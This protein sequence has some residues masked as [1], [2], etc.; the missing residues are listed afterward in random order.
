[1]HTK[2]PKTYFNTAYGREGEL[3]DTNMSRKE[4]AQLLRK[5]LKKEFPQIKVAVRMNNGRAINVFI[6]SV[7]FQ[8]YSTPYLLAKKS[9]DYTNYNAYIKQYTPNYIAINEKGE[10]VTVER[11]TCPEFTLQGEKLLRKLEVIAN[12]YRYD[13]SDLMTD[14]FETNFYIFI[15]YDQN[16]VQVENEI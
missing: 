4:A 9:N 15:K 7:P 2:T 3:Y 6:R 16:L 5:R 1:M 12:E 10:H 13:D 14:Y 8:V 11:P